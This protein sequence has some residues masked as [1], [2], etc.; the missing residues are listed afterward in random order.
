MVSAPNILVFE[1]SSR[2]EKQEASLLTT[3]LP[4]KVDD[5]ATCTFRQSTPDA[6]PDVML[7]AHEKR[8]AQLGVEYG[9][10]IKFGRNI[11]GLAE[12]VD[13]A[14]QKQLGG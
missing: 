10:P 2:F 1:L 11:R 9:P 7:A 3:Y 13:A 14:L 5:P 6:G 12:S 8:K 4:Y